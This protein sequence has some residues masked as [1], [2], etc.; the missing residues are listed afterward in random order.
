VAEVASE[1]VGRGG[2]IAILGI[3]DPALEGMLGDAVRNHRDHVAMLNGFNEPMAH[4]II[5]ASD[6]YLMPSRFEPCG[7]SQI[8]AQRYG[9]LPIA[10]AT[11]G[12]VDT[13]EDGET[14][15]LFADFTAESF[16][17]AIERAFETFVDE[18]SLA[19]M[20]RAAM[21][22][23]FDWSAPSVDYVRLYARLTGKPALRVAH[24]PAAVALSPDLRAASYM[25]TL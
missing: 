11:G 18:R 22:R 3:G 25:S 5:A 6:F 4:R 15:F 9:S 17:E 20:R 23:S 10:H 16:T 14:G 7:L 21:S 12:L 24:R 2:Q 1:I 19:R 13:I 8:H